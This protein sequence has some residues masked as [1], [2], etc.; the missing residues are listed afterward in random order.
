[1][2][3]LEWTGERLVTSV[4]N[5]HGVIEHLH[6]YAIALNIVK[7]K[8][9]L[10]IASGEGYGSF[11]LSQEAEKVFGVDVDE[12]SIIHAKE[13]Y[14][15]Q[16]NLVFKV[17]NGKCIPIEDKI[18]DVVISFETIEHIFEQEDFV[19]EIRRVLKDDGILLMSSP[20]KDIYSER[21]KDNPYHL[22]ELTKLEFNSLLAKYFKNVIPFVQRY[23]IGSLVHLDNIDEQARFGMYSG[24]YKK[25]ENNL[26]IHKF[27]NKPFFN[28]SMASNFEIEKSILMNSA[29]SG[30]EPIEN[31]IAVLKEKE[32]FMERSSVIKMYFYLRKIVKKSILKF[33]QNLIVVFT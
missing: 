27:Y 21:D 30:F 2:N 4:H 3:D 13:K 26:N 20:E 28:I 16:S 22:K 15:N 18:I 7:N 24:D 10:D 14:K 31:E 17:G 25:I 1:M 6:R 12:R 19:R 5:I 23:F 11:L 8:I 32:Y 33:A 29:F 9:V